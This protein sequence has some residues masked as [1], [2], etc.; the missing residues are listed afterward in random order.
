MSENYTKGIQNVLKLSKQISLKMGHNYVGSEHFILGMIDDTTGRAASTLIALG[1]DLDSIKLNIQASIK[2]SEG[3]SVLGHLPLT[4]RAERILRNSFLESKK[5]LKKAANQ[6]DL[7]L[8]ISNEK[9]CIVSEV[10]K[11][12]S[13]DYNLIKSYLDS[14]S[15]I[16]IIHK[17]NINSKPST[18]TLDTFSRNLTKLAASGQLDP[19]IGRDDEIKRLSQILSRRKKN[20]PVLIGEPGVGK[21]AIVEGLAL[22]I[23]E[24]KV[25]R[26]LWDYN[27]ISLDISG[28]LAGTKYRGQFEERMRKM[29]L[30]LEKSSNI[31]LFID[32]LHTIVGAGGTSGS[33]D[34][35]NMFKP[36]LARGDIQI[37]GATTLNEYRKYI[38]IDG[39]LERRFQKIIVYQPSIKDSVNILNGIKDKYEAHHKVK[40]S[41]SAIEA[42]VELSDRYINDRFLPD[43]A[44]DIM[45]EVCSRISLS[46]VSIPKGILMLE[47][48]L[49]NLKEQKNKEIDSQKFE[50]AAKLRDKEKK[51]IDK[52]NL[53]TM[54]NSLYEN[55][56]NQIEINEIDVADTVSIIT[57]IPISKINEKDSVKILNIKDNIKKSI[58]GQD[59]SIDKLVAA[60]QRSRSGFKN[61]LHP[62]GSFMFLGPTGVGKTELAKQ[63]ALAL[64]DKDESLIKIDMSEYMERFN[65]SRLIGAP[66]G[67]VGYE[68]G[69][70]LTE[71]VRR[72]PYSIVLFDE[73]EKAHSDVFNILLQILDEGQ[74][75]DSL[76][77]VI[78]FKN[79]IIIMTSNIGTQNISSSNIG[80]I[81]SNKIQNVQEELNKEVKKYFKPEFLNRL[82]E[83]IIFNSLSEENL[84]KIIDLQLKDLRKNLKRKRMLLRVNNSAKKI[85]LL[86]GTH[87]EWGA[88]P[89]RCIIQD[90]IENT[91]SYKY[92]T[93]EL[94]EDSIIF[95]TGKVDELIFKSKPRSPISKKNI[96]KKITNI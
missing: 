73:I 54:E 9:D 65:V 14:K 35:A 38:E 47:K 26:L 42:C 46:N 77:H 1:A 51:I 30:E 49:R 22:R 83:V 31:I 78:D 64:F 71:K 67:Y 63:L 57:G 59:Y 75:T 33:L 58:I 2:S 24:K 41:S 43:K 32:E 95:I 39:A 3:A 82:D 89:I 50:V 15:S 7:L 56:K 94:S 21:T 69:G 27:I 40:L 92:L 86:N 6:N 72:N 70:M 16:K 48:K 87:R 4:R 85:L 5:R 53:M 11:S 96:P 36:S 91:I 37:V 66:P 62:I 88:R 74:L 13:I 80:F 68:E 25:P 19:V 34:A 84:Y 20:N 81:D 28:M 44:I 90:D 52:I 45:D 93:G 60:I 79:T 12:C 55:E 76:G 18:S 8:S 29:M 17:K 10:L 61:P 23:L